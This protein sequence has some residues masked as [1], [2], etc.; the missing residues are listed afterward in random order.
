MASTPGSG[1]HVPSS[2]ATLKEGWLQKRGEY[3]KNW[4]PRWFVLKADGSFLGYKQKPQHGTEPLNN[5][6]VERKVLMWF[7]D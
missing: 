4:R 3:I 7:K 2:S 1:A 5:F 6:K